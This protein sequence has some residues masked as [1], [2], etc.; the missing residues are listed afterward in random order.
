[1][2]NKG[3]PIR[4]ARARNATPGHPAAPDAAIVPVPAGVATFV[5]LE[6]Q[7]ADNGSVQ[8]RQRHGQDVEAVGNDLY[9]IENYIVA[10]AAARENL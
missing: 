7:V 10:G 1:M 6:Q 2:D 9:R 4:V 5:E 8:W 3:R